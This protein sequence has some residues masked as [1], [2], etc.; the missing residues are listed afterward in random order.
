MGALIC[1]RH[2]GATGADKLMGKISVFTGRAAEYRAKKY[3][4]QQGLQFVAANERNQ[5]GEIDLIMREHAVLVFVEVRCRKNN[6]YGSA[7]ESISDYKMDNIIAAADYYL[8]HNSSYDGELNSR[9]DIVAYNHGLYK[10]P[11]WIKNVFYDEST[12]L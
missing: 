8:L 2:A 1:L 3:L 7:L 10:P 11:C 12:G 4:Q 5:G 6:R 9:F